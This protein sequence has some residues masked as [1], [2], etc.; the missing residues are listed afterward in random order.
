MT[1]CVWVVL[2]RVLRD[3]GESRKEWEPMPGRRVAHF[4]DPCLRF[5]RMR[6]PLTTWKILAI[7]PWGV[8]WFVAFTWAETYVILRRPTEVFARDTGRHF[9]PSPFVASCG[10]YPK[11]LDN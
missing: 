7:I 1:P 11:F 6:T 5:L 8:L 3:R 2:S 10:P 4:W 9:G